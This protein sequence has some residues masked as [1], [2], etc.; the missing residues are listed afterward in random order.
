MRIEILQHFARNRSVN[1]VELRKFWHSWKLCLQI[2][3]QFLKL[4]CL[5]LFSFCYVDCCCKDYCKTNVTKIS[6]KQNSSGGWLLA[7]RENGWSTINLLLALLWWI[8]FSKCN[9][10]VFCLFDEKTWKLSNK[11][12][13]EKL[14]KW[15]WFWLCQLWSFLDQRTKQCVIWQ[16]NK[17]RRQSAGKLVFVIW[18]TLGPIWLRSSF[19]HPTDSRVFC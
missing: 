1:K 8:I 18:S 5:M 13:I 7:S 10:L 4:F 17:D 19:K 12:V 3:F 9:S 14:W 6:K 15:C 2:K 16:L 11:T